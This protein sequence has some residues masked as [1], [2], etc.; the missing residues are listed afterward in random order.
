[1]FYN[2]VS[3]EKERKLKMSMNVNA[4]RTPQ[5]TTQENTMKKSVLKGAL[6]G[7]GAG[8]VGSVLTG[9]VLTP[10]VLTKDAFIKESLNRIEQIVEK[11]PKEQMEQ[12]IN[13]VT[14]I[15]ETNYEPYREIAQM[16]ANKFKRQIP[17]A[18]LIGTAA[19]CTVG[20]G[21]AA[22]IHFAKKGKEKTQ[23]K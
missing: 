7:S 3:I 8:A 9:C 4:V 23:T 15:A 17:K 6:I 18:A 22:V 12:A 20:A 1:M 16:A 13:E 14:Q 10:K 2:I 11:A 21:I 5:V 19:A